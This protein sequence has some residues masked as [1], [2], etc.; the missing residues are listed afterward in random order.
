[1]NFPS[2]NGTLATTDYV[3]S[4]IPTKTSDLLNDSGFIT[5]SAIPSQVSEFNN[6]AGYITASAIPSNVSVFN[7]DAGYI[8]ASAIPSQVSAFQNDAGY[9]T[10]GSQT[11]QDIT[12]SV[13]SIGSN[14]TTLDASVISLGTS[15]S[16]LAVSMSGKRN[17][18]DLTYVIPSHPSEDNYPELKKWDK[19]AISK[20]VLTITG[21]GAES[22]DLNYFTTSPTEGLKWIGTPWTIYTSDGWYFYLK[23]SDEHQGGAFRL[24]QFLSGDVTFS[25]GIGGQAYS[26]KLHMEQNEYCNIAL[27]YQTGTGKLHVKRNGVDVGTYDPTVIE[28]TNINIV[29]PTNISQLDNDSGFV[30][31]TTVASNY[32]NKTQIDGMIGSIN[33]ALDNINGEV[34]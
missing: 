23:D 34:I 21:Y 14:V 12:A 30:T 27:D 28:G 15:V 24:E 7:N 29:V 18:P 2:T 26:A 17:Y 6:D 31:A 8:T 25:I 5:A 9:L 11:I 16:A 33:T 19:A 32:Y 1:M 10:A 3:T 20:F 22:W 13:S 4:Q